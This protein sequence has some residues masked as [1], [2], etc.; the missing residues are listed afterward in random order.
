MNVTNPISPYFN[1]NLSGKRDNINYVLKNSFAFGG[2]NSSVL[3]KRYN[4]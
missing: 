1:F 4:K 2:V 3:Y